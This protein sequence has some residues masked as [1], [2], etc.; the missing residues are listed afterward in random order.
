MVF[1]L[2]R[3]R[4]DGIVTRG[5]LQ[6]A[7]VRMLLFGLI[8]TLEMLLL[9]LVKESYPNDVWQGS[10]KLTRLD[11]AKALHAQ[12]QSRNEAI[13]LS[14]CL[15]FCDKT[16]LVLD[17]P[18]AWARLCDSRGTAARVLRSAEALR[19]RLAH[20]QDIVSGSSWPETIDLV[21]N[22]QT[23][24]EHGEATGASRTL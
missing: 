8:T 9:S 2:D 24:L 17:K 11:K 4:V 21:G 13:E 22:I 1:V 20:A 3:N 5:D 15:Q 6:K 10:L 12:R 16:S 7:P 14:D 18:D 19:D 23:F